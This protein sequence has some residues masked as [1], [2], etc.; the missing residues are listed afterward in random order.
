M[1][2]SSSSTY[3]NVL[4]IGPTECKCLLPPMQLTSWTKENP[5][6]RFV[7]CP[8][9][10]LENEWYRS[11]LYEMYRLL[12]PSQKRELATEIRSQEE[13]VLLQLEMQNLRDDLRKSQ[14]K[15]YF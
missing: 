11:H 7:V 8:N 6:R 12:N 2:S 10:Y 3:S 15:A 9:R 13:V 1:P 5:A 14:K 4:G